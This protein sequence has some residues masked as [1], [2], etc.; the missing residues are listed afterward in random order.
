MKTLKAPEGFKFGNTEHLEGLLVAQIV[1]DIPS[2]KWVK[3]GT[4]LDRVGFYKENYQFHFIFIAG[5]VGRGGEL[6][7]NEPI[8]CLTLKE[9][10]A[11]EQCLRD[12]G[13][14]KRGNHIKKRFRAE[15]VKDLL[16]VQE[17]KECNISENKTDY[18]MLL[19]KY[20]SHILE[21]EGIT[22]I[23]GISKSDGF[24]AI[25]V[26]ELQKIDKKF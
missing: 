19:K 17:N 1:P 2:N 25:E 16:S 23:N 6:K 3:F 11:A 24:T 10:E 8:K 7:P 21:I 15:A 14:I 20:I 9:Q 5:G 13:Y 12:M 22:Y 18:E 26:K 4:N